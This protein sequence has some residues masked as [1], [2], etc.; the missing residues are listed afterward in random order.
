MT[1]DETVSGIMKDCP[2]LTDDAILQNLN[3]DKPELVQRYLY[4]IAAY[5]VN[6]IRQEECSERDDADYLDALGECA[7]HI[8]QLIGE[9]RTTAKLSTY[10]QRSFSR[11]ARR[12]LAEQDRGGMVTDTR[13]MD[14][15]PYVGSIEALSPGEDDDGNESE[16]TWEDF[17]SYEHPPAGY[18]DPLRELLREEAVMIAAQQIPPKRRSLSSKQR[19]LQPI[20]KAMTVRLQHEIG[21]LRR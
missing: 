5:A 6:A 1:F 16:F 21:K 19:K 3:D 15:V 13:N 12:Y 14:D 2:L 10:A 4:R 11:I 18:D 17:V 9:K 8:N 7:L 20:D